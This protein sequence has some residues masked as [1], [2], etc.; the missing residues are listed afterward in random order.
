MA[1]I[2]IQCPQCRREEAKKCRQFTVNAGLEGIDRASN[3][4]RMGFILN[5][6]I[7]L[8]GTGWKNGC[9]GFRRKK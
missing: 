4:K 5:S 7:D 3:F 9:A 8:I 2:K 1:E 6:D